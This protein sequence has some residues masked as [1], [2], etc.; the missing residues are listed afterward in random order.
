MYTNPGTIQIAHRHMNVEIGAETALFPEKEYIYCMGFS[1]QCSTF[2][3]SI[4]Q[5]TKKYR[6]VLVNIS[7]SVSVLLPAYLPACLPS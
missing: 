1:L 7:K 4:K 3:M 6:T 5:K 2:S